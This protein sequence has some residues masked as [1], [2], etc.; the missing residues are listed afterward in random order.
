[1]FEKVPAWSPINTLIISFVF[2]VLFCLPAIAAA[3]ERVV[4]YQTTASIQPDSSVQLTERI[5]YDFDSN[6]KR[7]IYRDID[8]VKKLDGK[9]YRLEIS[10]VLVVDDTGNP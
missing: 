1:M 10:D 3:Q 6:L 8:T 9:S 2:G 5:A 7:G 4:S